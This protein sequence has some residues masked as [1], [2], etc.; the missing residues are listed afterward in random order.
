MDN[1]FRETVSIC[2]DR[3]LKFSLRGIFGLLQMLNSRIL[4]VTHNVFK[5]LEPLVFP[6]VRLEL[7]HQLYQHLVWVTWVTTP[8][9]RYR[10]DVWIPSSV[11]PCIMLAS[12]A[13]LF[14]FC[15]APRALVVTI[16]QLDANRFFVSELLCCSSFLRSFV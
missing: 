5:L 11:Y 8:T 13:R 3:I 15:S 6:W 12:C 1:T 7:V 9:L 10:K 16:P 4:I 2:I 14:E